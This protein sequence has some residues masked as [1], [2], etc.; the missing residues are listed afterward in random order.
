MNVY[1]GRGFGGSFNSNAP[2]LETVA[3]SI[4]S[5]HED[6]GT[7]GDPSGPPP[8]SQ[9]WRW[10]GFW[11][12]YGCFGFQKHQKQIGHAVLFPETAEPVSDAPATINFVQP[13]AISVPFVA[14]PPSPASFVPSEPPSAPQSPVGLLSLTSIAGSMYSPPGPHSMF[15]IGPYAHETQLVSPPVFSTFTTEP[16]TAPVTP[17]SE[18]I[19]MTTPASPEVPFA[20]FLSPNF[21]N[22]EGGHGFPFY[23]NEFLP[24]QLSPGSPIGHLISPSSGISGSGTS[25]PFP[26]REFA[27]SLSLLQF[28]VDQ[29]SNVFNADTLR[30]GDWGSRNNSGSVTPDSMTLRPAPCS[31]IFHLLSECENKASGTNA[32]VTLFELPLGE[33]RGGES[34]PPAPAEPGTTVSRNS[35]EVERGSQHINTREAAGN[36]GLDASTSCPEME[37]NPND[38]EEMT[39]WQRCR[40]ITLGSSRD[41]TFDERDKKDGQRTGDIAS[42]WSSETVIE[43]EQLSMKDWSFPVIQPTIS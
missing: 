43:E 8:R 11:R 22:T 17:P 19:N 27:A 30:S 35:V 32:A 23:Q 20:H 21:Q 37:K 14:P 1:G 34:N 31:G 3:A 5:V 26:G 36:V 6:A 29:T 39:R 33:V 12:L 41:F 25:S 9:K 15:E 2:A 40:S 16:S 7:R 18:S 13:T 4:A 10:S 24:Y 38:L 28:Q 42:G